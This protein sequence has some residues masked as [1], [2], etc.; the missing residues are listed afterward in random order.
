[1]VS[2]YIGINAGSKV[3]LCAEH[4]I[5]T[6]KIGILNCVWWHKPIVPALRDEEAEGYL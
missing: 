5:I 4:I 3:R 2:K 6:L 1:M